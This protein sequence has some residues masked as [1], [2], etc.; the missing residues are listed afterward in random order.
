VR[1]VIAS[2]FVALDGVIE[3]P[4]WTF[5]F[6]GE[7]Q[8]KFKFDELSASDALLLGRVTYE[9]FAAAWPRMTEQAGE[10]SASDALLLGRYADMMNGYPKYVVATTLEEPLEWNNSTL[11]EGDV[12]EEVS[13][14][15]R[16][17]GKDILIF[18]SGNLVNTLMRHDLIDEYRLMIFPI[19]VG[20][21]QRL[22]ADGIDEMVLELVDT[23]TFGSG[24]VVLTYRSAREGAQ[25]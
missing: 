2:E 18:G 8:Q 1:K 6:T 4:S 19:I 5:R 22:F 23:E 15:K 25:G 21:G 14:L 12:A 17:P 3:N 13:K 11:I 7:E 10:L 9:G 24:V 16:Q 20:S